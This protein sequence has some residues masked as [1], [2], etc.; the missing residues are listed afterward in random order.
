MSLFISIAA[1]VV[2][3]LALYVT[4][5]SRTTEIFYAYSQCRQVVGHDGKEG[6]CWSFTAA[7]SDTFI[8]RTFGKICIA[9]AHAKHVRMVRK[10]EATQEST[11]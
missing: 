8:G 3:C 5:S 11:T 10:L 9:M 2:A 6:D 4:V 7:H 1:L